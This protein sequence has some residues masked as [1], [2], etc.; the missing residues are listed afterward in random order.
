MLSDQETLELAQRARKGER[1]ALGRL[2]GALRP[3]ICR[4]ALVITGDPDDAEDVA[5]VVLMKIA[6]S[7]EDFD[8]RSKVTSWVYRITRNASLDHMRRR[9]RN[10]RLAD[11][12][13]Q[14]AQAAKPRIADPLDDIEMK[15]TVGLI[16]TLLAE[17]P[18]KQREVFD[19]VDLQGL[20]P[21]E[22]A[23][24][25]EMNPN[26]ARVHLLRARRTMR[27][28]MLARDHGYGGV[29]R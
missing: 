9:G 8:G 26:T 5:Q 14:L 10:R 23:E 21:K 13:A 28:A 6:G 25:L 12:L 29:G 24:M 27:S 2:A 22:A 15:R 4:W 19:L 3:L 17:L 20:K 7:M 18:L 1:E 11:K 16:R